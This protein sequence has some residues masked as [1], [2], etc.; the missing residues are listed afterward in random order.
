MRVP[1]IY[2][3]QDFVVGQDLTLDAFASGHICRVLRMKSG[4]PLILFNG[5]G[6][7][8][9]AEL[10]N[11]DPKQASVEI[12]EFDAV[13]RESHLPIHLGL[14]LSRGD[15]FDWAIQ[16]AVE[17][18]VTSITPLNCSRSDSISDTKRLAKKM[19][20]WNKLI[21]SACEQSGRTRLPELNEPKPCGDW[22]SVMGKSRGYF[23]VPGKQSIG[24][25][26]SQN[27]E[28][29]TAVGLAIGPEGGFTYE[30][31]ELFLEEGFEAVSL[32]PRVLRTETAPVV[33]ITLFQYLLGDIS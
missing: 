30:E 17:L 27:I 16:K 10:K 28:A 22:A 24:A 19:Q 4:R 23:F 31:E 15:R 32:G 7:E 18:G 13:E 26:L 12:L 14:G 5:R 1:R 25:R 8:Y 11:A 20:H 9:K 29:V 21:L 3:D 2:V 6:G 33:A